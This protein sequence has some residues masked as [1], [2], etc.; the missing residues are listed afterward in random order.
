MRQITRGT[1][2]EQPR[3]FFSWTTQS[4]SRSR[5]QCSRCCP[6]WPDPTSQSTDFREHIFLVCRL[7]NAFGIQNA[8]A[9]SV[10]LIHT[11]LKLS[12]LTH[13][14]GKREDVGGLAPDT[15][16]TPSF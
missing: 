15:D 6:A 13:L 11:Y 1:Q 5:R 16:P 3:L 14:S 10:G 12:Q 9:C 2:L 7:E 4:P 8:G